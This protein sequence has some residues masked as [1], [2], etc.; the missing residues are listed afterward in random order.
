MNNILGALTGALSG[1]VAGCAAGLAYSWGDVSGAFTG[2]RTVWSDCGPH[3]F[4]PLWIG[5]VIGLVARTERDSSS[6]FVMTMLCGAAAGFSTP[7]LFSLLFH[8][9]LHISFG[10]ISIAY[11]EEIVLAATGGTAALFWYFGANK[12]FR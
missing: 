4:I 6:G 2:W 12:I 5:T 3:L 11:A 1:A 7:M 10:F 8:K 9:T